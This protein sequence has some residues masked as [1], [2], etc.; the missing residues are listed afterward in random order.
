MAIPTVRS[1]E[2]PKAPE[3]RDA[4][5]GLDALEALE[6]RL[7]DFVQHQLGDVRALRLDGLTR[8]SGGLSREHWEF[9]AR[10]QDPTGPRELAL[11][12]RRDGL[13][14]LLDTDRAVEFA[15][16]RALAS[17]DVPTPTVHWLD[18][19]GT[20]L[21]RPSLV[22]ERVEGT[23]DWMVLNG[24]RPLPER[25][26]LARGF[27]DL[28]AAV[29]R[30]HWQ[31]LGLAEVLGD[32]GHDAASAELARWEGE[33]RRNQ[34]EPMPELDL[35]LGWLRER[36][37][38]TM[39]AVL[40]HGDF[41]PGNALLHGTR[42]AALLDWETAH[43]GDP[44]EDLGWITNPVRAGEHQI[45]DSWERRAIVEA[46]TAATGRAV[47]DDVLTWWNVFSCWKLAVIVLTGVR[48]FVDGR[49]DRAHHSPTWLF[50]AMLR[51]VE[52]D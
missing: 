52:G 35:V 6:S 4:P 39:D 29:Q 3:G 41:K 5:E 43:L 27:I 9:R 36:A 22:M 34:L 49:L 28:L 46:Y 10:W 1:A 8:T 12:A 24:A 30:V 19:D 37:E 44:M 11:I 31:D 48:A 7:T 47:D 14:G 17:T 40:V 38:P 51:M 32:P 26:E 13:G 45:V 23:C 20:W 18:R 25:L 2:R 33:L 50:R 42:I 15:V 21:G 16:L